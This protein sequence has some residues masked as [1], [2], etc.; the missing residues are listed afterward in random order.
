M[1]V[2]YGFY[3]SVGK[4]R[5]YNAVDMSRLLDG[6][7]SDGVFASIGT[8]FV[9]TAG[10]GM[11]VNVGI[12]RA[13]FNSTWTLNDSIL[14]VAISQSELT[15][16]R[17]DAIVIEVDSS[18]RIN[19]IKVVKGTPASSPV[20]P[21]LVN[22][23]YVHQHVLAYVYVGANVTSI[24][25]TNL[26]N[27]VGT[28]VCPFITGVI[29]TI[30]SDGITNI[31]T[32]R[33]EDWFADLQTTLS[34]DVAGNLYNKITDLIHEGDITLKASD[35]QGTEAPYYQDISIYG[36]TTSD[37]P[38][39]SAV[40]G[41]DASSSDLINSAYLLISNSSVNPQVSDGKIRFYATSKPSVSIPLHWQ[42]AKE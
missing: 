10:T 19:S 29:Q 4:D 23:D 26:T 17:I 14:P 21:T 42:Y 20:N 7:I 35:W 30:T 3:N 25:A 8:S 12:G 40:T 2:T 37:W 18:K 1:S 34:G 38:I 11:S 6:I 15:L 41:S 32:A 13:W 28:S 24:L 16:N 36:I 9:V 5:V 33:F 22:T 27:T 39:I 31:L